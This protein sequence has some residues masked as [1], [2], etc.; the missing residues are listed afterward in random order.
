M[1]NAEYNIMVT[2]KTYFL[3]EMVFC[4]DLITDITKAQKAKQGRP[5]RR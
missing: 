1:K 3:W 2:R 5:W 4:P